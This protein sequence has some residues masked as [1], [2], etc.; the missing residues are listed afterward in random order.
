MIKNEPYLTPL[1]SSLCPQLPNL[2]SFDYVLDLGCGTRPIFD[3]GYIANYRYGADPLAIKNNGV[4]M[5]QCNAEKLPYFDD[6]FDLIVSRV[7]F[8]YTHIPRALAETFRVLKPGGRLWI[9][10]HLPAMSWRRI[11]NDAKDFDIVDIAY[12]C[13]AIL[14][15]GLLNISNLQI[16]WVN[17]R[18]ESVQTPTSISRA[19]L[20]A[21]FRDVTTC[22]S[23]DERDRLHFAA[24]GAKPNGKL[25]A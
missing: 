19:M 3:D 10:L 25:K 4:L 16:P 14:N 11:K 20:H 5:E 17:G 6:T 8:P 1:F 9:T 21:G 24:Q 2:Q 18:Y 15:C 13:Y 7:A 23:A 12:Q 22:L